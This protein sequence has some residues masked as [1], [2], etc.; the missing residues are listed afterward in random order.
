MCSSE[1][2]S[3]HWN[4]VVLIQIQEQVLKIILTEHVINK[5]ILEI[6]N[7]EV[8]VIKT[9]KRI[10]LEYLRELSISTDNATGKTCK[11]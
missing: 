7:K 1:I 10:I 5:I 11:Q 9:K 6:I 2:N 8:E 4:T 3:F